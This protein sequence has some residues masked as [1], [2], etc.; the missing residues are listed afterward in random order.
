LAPR[1]ILAKK[2]ICIAVMGQHYLNAVPAL[3]LTPRILYLHQ[4]NTI[5]K[6][7]KTMVLSIS[8]KLQ[9]YFLD[10]HREELNI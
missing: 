7:A 3:D 1:Y 5:F 2:A 6:K 9:I 10:F 4:Y 8:L